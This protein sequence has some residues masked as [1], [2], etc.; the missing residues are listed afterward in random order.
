MCSEDRSRSRDR[1]R[2]S[3]SES[4]PWAD[5]WCFQKVCRSLSD[6]RVLRQ[7]QWWYGPT[8]VAYCSWSWDQQFSAVA[9]H[10]LRPKNDVGHVCLFSPLFGVGSTRGVESTQQGW[11]WLMSPWIRLQNYNCPLQLQWQFLQYQCQRCQRQDSRL[12]DATYRFNWL[13]CLNK[14]QHQTWANTVQLIQ[15]Q[16]NL[17]KGLWFSTARGRDFIVPTVSYMVSCE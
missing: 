10:V 9:S 15:V 6:G 12:S 13:N 14:S 7:L 11:N 1:R 4:S 2:S 5:L 17:V 16:W 8:L 3:S